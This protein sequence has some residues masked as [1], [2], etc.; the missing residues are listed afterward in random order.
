MKLFV[1]FLAIFHCWQPWATV[2]HSLFLPWNQVKIVQE[3]GEKQTLNHTVGNVCLCYE[4]AIQKH[5]AGYRRITS[6][7]RR[8]SQYSFSELFFFFSFF[9]GGGVNVIYSVLTLPFLK[10]LKAPW[11]PCPTHD[12]CLLLTEIFLLATSNP[13]TQKYKSGR[14]SRLQNESWWTVQIVEQH[15]HLLKR[16]TV[17]SFEILQQRNPF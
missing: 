11:S 12:F 13:C 8:C 6:I 14:Q 5:R 4:K 10:T 15:K 3:R 2:F 17:N 16:T 9:L 7:V 1:W